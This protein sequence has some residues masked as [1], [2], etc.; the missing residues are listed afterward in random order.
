MGGSRKPVLVAVAGVAIAT[1][2]LTYALLSDPH[3]AVHP[4]VPIP[5]AAAASPETAGE[6]VGPETGAQ[7]AAPAASAD[8]P[9][10]VD[11]PE[12]SPVGM[13]WIPGGSFRMGSATGMADERP[14]HLVAL[15]GFWMDATEV[16][17]SQF[18]KFVDATGYATIAETTP[19]R[20]DFVGQVEDISK[21]P[22][23]NLK[24]GA[25]CFIPNFDPKKIIKSDPNFPYTVWEYVKGANWR[26]PEGP[27]TSIDDRMEH[28]VVHVAWADAVA[29]CRWAGKRLP[30]EAEWEYAARGGLDAKAYPWGDEL[31]PEG[32]WRNNV[33]QG[34]FPY[35][36]ELLD[37]FQTTAPVRTFPPNSY[38]LYEISGNVWEWCTDNY[39][40]DYYAKSPR[41]DPFGPLDSFDPNE[42]NIPKRVQRGGSFMCSDNYCTGYRVAARMKGD[43]SS[44]TSHC[45]FRCVQTPDMRQK[46]ADRKSAPA[47]R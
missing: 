6:E 5:T 24:P 26:H 39:R 32:K 11:E 33:W 40:P 2:A 21:I 3:Q 23:E 34:E 15:D 22:E 30:T 13:V 28:P 41:R 20:E 38:G 17:N 37:G 7:I 29:Y 27:D 25:I 19:K 43:I 44:G 31:Q 35:K 36:N 18:T 16:T 45:G 12:P 46:Q 8:E 42:P 47:L 4:P 1:C 14:V 9:L 10:I